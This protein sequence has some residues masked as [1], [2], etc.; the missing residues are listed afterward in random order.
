M[1]SAK[2][3]NLFAHSVA[4]FTILL[5][6]DIDILNF[7]LSL[8]ISFTISNQFFSCEYKELSFNKIF[9]IGAYYY[10]AI[11]PLFYSLKLFEATT[12]NSW[13]LTLTSFVV[14][15]SL[16]GYLIGAAIFKHFT[17]KENST[18]QHSP[19]FTHGTGTREIDGFLIG[20]V[21]ITNLTLIVFFSEI[22][23]FFI[24]STVITLLIYLK[25][26]KL[27]YS[28]R[29]FFS[30]IIVCTSTIAIIFLSTSR[31]DLIK[32]F[33]LMGFLYFFL[34]RRSTNLIKLFPVGIILFIG[35]IFITINRS[36]IDLS[37]EDSIVSFFVSYEGIIEI[38][39]ALGDIGIAFDNLV[40]LVKNTSFDELLLGSSLVRPL[41][42]LIPRTL[43]LGKPIDTQLLIVDERYG[44]LS[45]FGGGTSQSITL[46]GEFYWNLSIFG[47]FFGFFLIAILIK[48]LD[49]ILFN[50]R[51]ISTVY[52]LAASS[53]FFFII[54]RG[55]YS[56]ELVYTL[57]SLIPIVFLIVLHKI[58]AELPLK[59]NN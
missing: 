6:Q 2:S 3:L 58:F 38:L 46:V 26:S 54:W 25:F 24:F 12:F 22:R 51:S 49:K 52:V 1:L 15:T 34:N 5:F 14:L 55:A 37:L 27:N 16:L 44:A 45:E 42:F 23:T 43:W 41:F 30:T 13:D 21:T 39:M 11:F 7:F 50:T 8:V 40:Y 53:P 31:S 36:N 47:T 20:L 32:L 10:L 29:V 18:S 59:K 57:I 9:L 48:N 19:R 28:F 35:G 56:S 4:P 17:N 33:I